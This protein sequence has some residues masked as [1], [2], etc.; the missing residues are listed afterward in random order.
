MRDFEETLKFLREVA[1]NIGKN[2]EKFL[3]TEAGDY[4]QLVQSILDK[5]KETLAV[6]NIEHELGT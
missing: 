3:E 4:Q 1:S 6:S 5:Y 2:S